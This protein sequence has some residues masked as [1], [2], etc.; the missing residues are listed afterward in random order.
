[1]GKNNWAKN[2]FFRSK[3]GVRRPILYVNWHLP[4]FEDKKNWEQESLFDE[5]K[6]LIK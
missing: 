3:E 2:K 6:T 5:K 1:M 4:W